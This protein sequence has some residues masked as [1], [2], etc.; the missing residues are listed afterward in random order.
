MAEPEPDN[1]YEIVDHGDETDQPMEE[2]EGEEGGSGI[3][4]GE[5]EGEQ[6]E[7]LSL[8]CFTGHSGNLTHYP[9]YIQFKRWSWKSI[10]AWKVHWSKDLIGK[11]RYRLLFLSWDILLDNWPS[12]DLLKLVWRG[13]LARQEFGVGF[14]HSL[15]LRDQDASWGWASW[16]PS[17]R[18]DLGTPDA[19]IYR[20]PDVQSST[21]NSSIWKGLSLAW[22]VISSLNLSL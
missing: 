15:W 6:P 11:G 14:L 7:D 9:Y 10:F 5:E 20:F 3:N 8:H 4:D 21:Q 12:L 13:T 18:Q 22:T 16:S 17:L 2:D 19:N 1:S